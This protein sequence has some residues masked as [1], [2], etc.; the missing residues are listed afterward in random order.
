VET[1]IVG[2]TSRSWILKGGKKAPKNKKVDVFAFSMEEIM[3]NGW[4]NDNRY[5]IT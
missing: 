3:E 5:Y 4:A 1:E 2:E